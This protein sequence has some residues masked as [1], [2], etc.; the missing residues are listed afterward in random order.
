MPTTFESQRDL[1]RCFCRRHNIGSYTPGEDRRWDKIK[2]DFYIRYTRDGSYGPITSRPNLVGPF[3]FIQAN[4][5]DSFRV[6]VT[7]T[8]PWTRYDLPR[9]TRRKVVKPGR[10]SYSFRGLKRESSP[11]RFLF[12]DGGDPI[13]EL[14]AL[15]AIGLRPLYVT[16]RY[17][18]EKWDMRERISPVGPNV[19]LF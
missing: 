12:I 3:G 8:T 18:R 19:D 13:R 6:C 14:E 7:F 16:A 2:Y 9:V 15:K 10:V 11:S 17:I 5:D 1:L 4:D